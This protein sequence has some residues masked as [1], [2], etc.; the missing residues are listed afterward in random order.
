M[1]QAGCDAR[2]ITGMR[3][4]VCC[5]SGRCW[6]CTAR[7]ISGKFRQIADE[8]SALVS[9]FKGS[10]AG[11]H[12]VGIARTEFLQAQ[13]GEE[14]YQ[15]M[16]EIKQSFDP[17]NLFNPGKIISD[18][19]Y[20]IDSICGRARVIRCPCRLS[21]CSLSRP[22]TVV[23]RQS[24][25][26]Q[27]LRRLSQANADHVPD[28]SRDRRGNHVH[29]R[30]CQCD[31]RCAGTARNRDPLHSA[32]LEAALSNCLSCNAC[33]NECPSNVNMALL[34][35]ELLHARIQRD[36]LNLRARMLSSV[37][38]LG[39]LGCADA[40]LA[41]FFLKSGSVR[42]IFGKF[43]GFTTE[44]PLPP[45]AKRGLIVGLRNGPNSARAYRGQVILWDDTF[46]RYHEPEIGIAAVAVLEAAGFEVT[47]PT[48]RKCCGRPGFQPGQSR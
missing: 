7:T 47:L 43:S 13:V 19:R 29:A 48:R 30:T 37:D 26:V 44:R 31:S 20:K 24:G 23:H 14:L 27:R 6:I 38:L 40:G 21:R 2:R 18:G 45:F 1:Q 11:E 33:T 25:A 3:R 28:V 39:R 34:K 9:Q 10:L 4:R 5:T 41:N 17:N 46:V 32:E 35:A 22:R 15:L 16:R 42:H 36:G 8:V 12:G